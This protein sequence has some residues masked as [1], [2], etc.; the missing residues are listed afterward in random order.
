MKPL[1]NSFMISASVGI[2]SYMGADIVHEVIG[3][4]GAALLAGFDITLL[5]SV[6]FKSNPVNILISICGPLSNLLLGLLL[7]VLL[8]YRTLKSAKTQ[9]FLITLMAY[10]LFWFS[11]TLVQ[12]GFSKEGDWSYA[13]ASLQVGSLG[14]PLLWLVGVLA[15]FMSI[16][17]VANRFLRLRF[18]IPGLPIK[19]STYQAYFFGIM[20]AIAAGLFYT[21]NPFGAAVEGLLEMAAS[22]P[23]LLVVRRMEPKTPPTTLRSHWVVYGLVGLAFLLFCFTLGK[24]FY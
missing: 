24:G 3:H 20:A 22:L 15:Y 8:G 19:Q 6:Y 21:T 16:K 13:M 2:A 1:L 4:G 17:L 5:T 18:Q 12:S 9:F 10:N 11:G 23:I 14:K 7:F